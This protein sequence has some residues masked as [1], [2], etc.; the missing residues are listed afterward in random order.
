MR[1]VVVAA[2]PKT[3]TTRGKAG[4][5]GVCAPTKHAP[6]VSSAEILDRCAVIVFPAI[7]SC[8]RCLPHSAIVPVTSVA[9]EKGPPKTMSSEIAEQ[10]S[11]LLV[12]MADVVM[13][14]RWVDV[15]VGVV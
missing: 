10:T 12:A 5:G 9:L 14:T 13:R 7:S 3:A 2:V 8:R 4:H 15:R 11:T 1:P 6:R